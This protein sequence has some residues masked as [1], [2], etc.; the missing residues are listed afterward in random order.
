MSKQ[1]VLIA[2]IEASKG[3]ED[4]QR[5]QLQEKLSAILETLNAGAEYLLSPYTITLGDEFQA[6]FD[7]ANTVFDHMM[8][9]MSALHPVMVRFSLGIGRISTPINPE[10]AI[11]MDGPAFHEA[12]EGIELLKESGFLFSIRCQNEN[13]KIAL[14][15]T[16]NSLQLLSKQI[17]SWNKRRLQI[18]YMLNDGYDYKAITKELDISQTAF[19]KNKE[20]GQLEVVQELTNNI[21]AFINQKLES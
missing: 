19:Y 11:G 1:L 7:Q 3:I 8:K 20:A 14:G 9:I 6:V 21:A 5:K 16:N 10:Q 12:R 17:R 13:E 15:I 4:Q 18:L 2:D